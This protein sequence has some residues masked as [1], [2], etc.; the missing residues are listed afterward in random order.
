AW[1]LPRVNVLLRVGGGGGGP[2]GDRQRRSS[3]QLVF[4]LPGRPDR[5]A[6]LA[7]KS[8]N[9]LAAESLRGVA[10]YAIAI[11]PMHGPAAS[12]GCRR[13]GLA[14]HDGVRIGLH[15]IVGDPL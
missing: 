7:K 12:L 3:C 11:V 2:P 8:I 14:I 1:P 5:F 13:D 6:H 9:V 10:K 4:G 15:A